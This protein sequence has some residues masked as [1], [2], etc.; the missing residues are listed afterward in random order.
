MKKQGSQTKNP[1]KPFKS[2]LTF[3]YPE[4]FFRWYQDGKDSSIFKK[5]IVDLGI[6]G[7]EKYLNCLVEV[8]HIAADLVRE[9]QANSYD[10]ERYLEHITSKHEDFFVDTPPNERPSIAKFDNYLYSWAIKIWP[11]A[12]ELIREYERRRYSVDVKES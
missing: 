6:K 2:L 11:R 1:T 4:I 9:N 7:T 8:L 5:A 10:G 12:L 3:P